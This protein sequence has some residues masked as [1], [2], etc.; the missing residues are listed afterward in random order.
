MLLIRVQYRTLWKAGE[1]VC[2]PVR[3]KY[4]IFH[5]P[6]SVEIRIG[7]KVYQTEP[8]AVIIS[9]PDEPRWFYFQRD[10]RFNFLHATLD[11]APLLESS[12]I[13]LGTILYPRDPE[14]LNGC[15]KRIRME[16]LSEEPD[17]DALTDL[18]VRELLLL[19]SRSL[20][21]PQSV[22]DNKLKTKMFKLRM[23]IL[24][25]PE[26]KWTVEQMAQLVSLSPSRFHVVYKALFRTTPMRDLI[27]A[28]IEHAKVLLLENR[29]ET[30]AVI[31]EKLSY[32]NP[33]DF[34]R[35]FTKVAGIS[36]GAFRKENK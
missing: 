22:A 23:E 36:P 18:Y 6:E 35:Q 5:F 21:K 28:R 25:R 16:Y 14:F 4:S 26:D 10:T 12:G 31:A 17:A 11:V 20:R 8:D 32:K 13:P 27:N 33:Y 30:L 19:L 15:F 3:E 24:S 9:R 1:C 34:C 7:D 2:V 29:E